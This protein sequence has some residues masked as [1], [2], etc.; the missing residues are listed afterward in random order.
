MATSDFR[1]LKQEAYEA[2]MQL[3]AL[4]L[5][6]YTFGNVSALD[7]A[8]GVFAIKPSGVDYETLKAEDM[9][10]VD[11]KG[12][13]VEGTLKPSSDTRTHLGLYNAY[14]QLGGVAHTHSLHAVSWAQARRDIP[15]F[16][17]THADHLTQPVP[18]TDTM[19]A[20]MIKGDYETETG[21]QIIHC[22]KKRKLNPSEVEMV[23]VAN[24]GPFSWGKTAAK[25]VYSSR[26]MEELAKM[27][28]LTLQ[29]NPKA[30][31]LGKELLNKHYQR[32]HGKGAYYGQV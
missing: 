13:V 28:L 10:I 9:V 21:N 12:K 15:V 14:P 29:I 2:N 6:L 7:K 4:G 24:H 17:T 32:K 30:K 11:L 20:A 16:G 1:D 23:L 18:C 5:V 22:F 31:T 8:R 26:V 19:T 3:P 27:A 25:A